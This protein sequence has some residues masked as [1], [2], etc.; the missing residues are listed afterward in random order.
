MRSLRPTVLGLV[1]ATF[2]GTSLAAGQTAAPATTSAAPEP[3]AADVDNAPRIAVQEAVALVQAGK[4]IIVDVR[5]QEAYRSGHIAGA[6]P[7]TPG[8]EATRAAELAKSGKIVITYCTC[9]AEHSAARAV[10]IL[11]RQGVTD[12]RALLG[13]YLEWV[14]AGHPIA[15]GDTQ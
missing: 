4:A 13:G 7:L 1:F 3:T 6:R 5:A 8:T 15:T 14:K 9:K 12:A 11:R 10:V 2:L